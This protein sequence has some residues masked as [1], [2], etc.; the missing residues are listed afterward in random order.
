MFRGSA[1][2][3]GESSISGNAVPARSNEVIFMVPIRPLEN[4][5]INNAKLGDWFRLGRLRERGMF[6]E[7]CSISL[8]NMENCAPNAYI[9]YPLDPCS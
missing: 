2:A 4:M 6:L 8:E 1:D 7:T 3:C 9:M 5:S